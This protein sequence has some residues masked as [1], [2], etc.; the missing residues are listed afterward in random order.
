MK[1]TIEVGCVPGGTQVRLVLEGLLPNGVY[2]M[3][4]VPFNAPG[5]VLDAPNFNLSGRGVVGYPDGSQS[6]FVASA[7][8]TATFE[9]TTPGGDLSEF[10]R[11]ADCALADEV[12]WH[13]IG[14]YHIDGQTHGP[15]LGPDGSAVEQFGFIFRG[16]DFQ[17]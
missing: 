9:A 13:V 3:W 15:D 8:G 5:P 11:I 2:T 7:A 16:E 12:E 17:E 6:R 4:N 14:A 10:G 1:G